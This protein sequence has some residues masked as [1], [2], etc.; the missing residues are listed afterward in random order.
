[1]Q[2]EE[3]STVIGKSVTIRGE[4]SASED[5][6]LDGEI[7]GTISLPANLLTIGPNARILADLHVR[8]VTIFGHV[9]GNIRASGRAD[10][11]QTAILRGDLLAARLSI[12]EKASVSGK[13][14][15][16]APGTRIADGSPE[17]SRVSHP[18]S[19]NP[20]GRIEAEA[21]LFGERKG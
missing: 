19:L 1:M 7:Q 6:F 13:I 12:E 3:N 8:D 18:A 20:T 9:E 4:L 17:L 16:A 11:R 15:V 2:P 10:L 21:P 14:E 5:L